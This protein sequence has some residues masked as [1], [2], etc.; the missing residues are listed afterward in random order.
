MFVEILYLLFG[1]TDEGIH[2]EQNILVGAIHE[3]P[4]QL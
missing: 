1:V 3:L 4:L 2:D